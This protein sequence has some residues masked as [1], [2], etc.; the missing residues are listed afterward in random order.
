MEENVHIGMKVLT[1]GPTPVNSA[2]RFCVPGLALVTVEGRRDDNCRSLPVLSGI[3]LFKERKLGNSHR[4][5][6][7]MKS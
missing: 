1:H 2:V 6:T 3:F 7:G 4:K 5:Q